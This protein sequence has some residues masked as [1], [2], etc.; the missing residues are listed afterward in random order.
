M[1]GTLDYGILYLH[2]NNLV[3]NTLSDLGWPHDLDD[4]H[5]KIGILIKLEV[6]P[7]LWSSKRQPAISLFSVEAEYRSLTNATK[8][9]IGF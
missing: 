8:E 9:M 7:I 3:L 1:K 4:K 5:S 2:E 6:S